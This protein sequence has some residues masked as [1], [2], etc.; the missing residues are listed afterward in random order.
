MTGRRRCEE[1]SVK[2]IGMRT[3]SPCSG[4]VPILV[5]YRII[6]EIQ[7]ALR[8]REQVLKP[9]S[10]LFNNK[11]CNSSPGRQ[12]HVE[13]YSSIFFYFCLILE[14]RVLHGLYLPHFCLNKVRHIRHFSQSAN[15]EPSSR[16]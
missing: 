2:G 1:R 15:E 3:I 9:F 10:G 14:G 11:D 6:P 13:F 8:R 7:A 12:G 4:I 16:H 5:I